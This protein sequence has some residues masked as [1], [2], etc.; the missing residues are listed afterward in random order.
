MS[1]DVLQ[2]NPASVYSGQSLLRWRVGRD[3]YDDLAVV[4]AA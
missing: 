3:A 4:T 1:V 2:R